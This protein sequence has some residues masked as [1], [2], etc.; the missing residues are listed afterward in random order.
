MIG[1]TLTELKS[2]EISQR[3]AITKNAIPQCELMPS[4]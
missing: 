2:E 4:K 1:D 3:E